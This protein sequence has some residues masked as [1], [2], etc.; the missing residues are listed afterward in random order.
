MAPRMQIRNLL[1]A[2]AA[3]AALALLAACS[4]Q[5]KEKPGGNKDVKIETPW[6]GLSVRTDPDIKDTGMPLYPGARRK[7][8]T[9]DDHHSANV[10][11]N[12]PGGFGLK[13]VAIEFVS[14]DAPDKVL[15][16]Y[17]GELK[18]FGGKF[19][20]CKDSSFIHIDSS[21]KYEDD[22]DKELTCGKRHGDATELKV[23]SP[24]NQHVVAVRSSGRG[25][26]FALVL[27]QKHGSEGTI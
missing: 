8:G 9:G 23:G 22:S 7:P 12:G 18:K 13:V 26:E 21:G 20:E 6:G 14:D 15:S 16:Y 17:R 1:L 25:S 19:L 24:N 4:I 11:I 27:L 5:T 3:L 2:L 10:D